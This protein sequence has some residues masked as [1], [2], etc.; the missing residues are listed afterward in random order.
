MVTVPDAADLHLSTAMTLEAWVNPASVTSDWRD[1]DLQGQRQ[2][3]PRRDDELGGKPAAGSIIGGSYAEAY[4]TD[5]LTT[6]TWTHL[7]HDL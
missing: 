7:A 6:S 5:D 4:G 2:L 3:L 1:V